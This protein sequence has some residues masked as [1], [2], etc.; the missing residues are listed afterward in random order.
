MYQ[1]FLVLSIDTLLN[2]KKIL[3]STNRDIDP[4]ALKDTIIEVYER[5]TKTP[6]LFEPIIEDK[7]LAINLKDWPVPNTDYVL[8]VKGLTSVAEEKLPSNIKRTI[9]FDSSVVSKVNIISPSMFEKIDDVFIELKELAEKE[10]DLIGSYY[11]EVSTD[12]AFYNIVAKGTF[13][14]TIFK[15]SLN[16][17]KQYFIRARVQTTDE[18]IQYGLWSEVIT[19][20]YGEEVEDGGI[21]D[22]EEPN[23]PDDDYPEIPDDD[24]PIVDL[25]EF[26]IIN[27]LDQGVTPEQLI[28]EFSKEIDVFS[29]DDIIITRKV[30]K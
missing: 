1:E 30:V 23:D 6:L 4:N 9:K 12:N 8:S 13:S 19:F 22:I 24:G 3:I 21:P 15:L 14:K 18:D 7:N 5:G 20:V 17:N 27:H 11:V 29:I 16:K 2:E 10:E 28:I 26:E 25:E